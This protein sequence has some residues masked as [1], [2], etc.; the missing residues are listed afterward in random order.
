MDPH[1]GNPPAI[2]YKIVL[3]V[4]LKDGIITKIDDESQKN[5]QERNE[6][7]A[8]KGKADSKSKKKKN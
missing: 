8:M 5:E 7:N 3:R 6:F 2:A 4:H 1:M